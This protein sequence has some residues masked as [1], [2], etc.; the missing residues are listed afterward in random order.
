MLIDEDGLRL[1]A[2]YAVR[3]VEQDECLVLETVYP[4][5]LL[6]VEEFNEA[7][8][9]IVLLRVDPR[10]LCARLEARKWPREK[11]AENCVSE[12]Y[13][14]LASDLVD[15]ADSVIEVDTTGRDPPGALEEFYRRLESW[16]TGIG[17]DWMENPEIVEFASRLL[18]GLDLDKYR[19]GV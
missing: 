14:V 17:I 9:V 4:R 7:T 18:A 10:E 3:V 2:L 12:A 11:I 15:W 16:R 1:V 6:E 5:S 8:A 19:L 13:G